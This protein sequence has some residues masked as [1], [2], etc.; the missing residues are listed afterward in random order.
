MADVN[1]FSVGLIDVAER[2][3]DV[4]DAAQGNG[5]RKAGSGAKWLL[6]PAAGAGAYALATSGSKLARG[7]RKLMSN[8]KDRATELPDATL[9]GRVKEATGLAE[10]SGSGNGR[11]TTRR[12]PSR[13]RNQTQ[14]RR[15]TTTSR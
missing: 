14:R 15:K 13:S 1:K 7:T 10:Q 9:L 5:A 8:A 4:V 3:A 12:S 11:P 6:L 2:F